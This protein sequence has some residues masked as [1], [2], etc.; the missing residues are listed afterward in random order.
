ME[1][2]KLNWKE[3]LIKKIRKKENQWEKCKEG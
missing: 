1:T 3:V 2:D